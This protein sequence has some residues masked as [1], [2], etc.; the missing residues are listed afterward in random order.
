MTWLQKMRD[1]IGGSV[2]REHL[3]ADNCAL[4]STE[5]LTIAFA[6]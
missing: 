5:L 6:H 2:G 1:Y 4:R 3:E